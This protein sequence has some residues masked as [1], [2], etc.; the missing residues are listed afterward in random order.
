[1]KKSNNKKRSR[2]KPFHR[3]PIKHLVKDDSH[4]QICHGPKSD[5]QEYR[6]A[7]TD[8]L[9][10]TE[11]FG[12]D[13]DQLFKSYNPIEKFVHKKEIKY[14]KLILEALKIRIR[15]LHK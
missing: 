12:R 2:K 5:F 13:L 14:A 1:M 3:K 6:D 8:V 15:G 4:L 11:D 7:L 9:K 10:T